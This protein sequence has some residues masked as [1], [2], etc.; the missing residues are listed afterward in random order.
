MKWGVNEYHRRGFDYFHGFRERKDRLLQKVLFK[1]GGETG[2]MKLE[3]VK[4]NENHFPNPWLT[5]SSGFQRQPKV[6]AGE[7][8]GSYNF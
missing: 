1:P 7:R 6:M 4:E 2:K 5:C 3:G 8:R